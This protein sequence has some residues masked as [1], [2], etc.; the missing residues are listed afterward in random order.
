MQRNNFV[1]KKGSGA[2]LNWTAD[3]T[4]SILLPLHSEL[5]SRLQFENKCLNL[6]K[7]CFTGMGA[8]TYA[9][10]GGISLKAAKNI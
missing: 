5:W 2:A 1:K 10:P 9:M 7:K 8:V 4:T 3:I 6:R